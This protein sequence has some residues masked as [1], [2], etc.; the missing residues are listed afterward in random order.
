MLLS[1]RSRKMSK[2]PSVRS[3]PDA[4]RNES[5]S[6]ANGQRENTSSSRL[7]DSTPI[8]DYMEQPTLAFHAPA[9]Y[10]AM[11]PPGSLSPQWFPTF[12]DPPE[13]TPA[14]FVPS[15]LQGH[16]SQH[17]SEVLHQTPRVVPQNRLV[18]PSTSSSSAP[19]ARIDLENLKAFEHKVTTTTDNVYRKIKEGMNELQLL[20]NESNT[21]FGESMILIN[22]CE[23]A[24]KELV[25]ELNRLKWVCFFLRSLN[26]SVFPESS[27]RSNEPHSQVTQIQKKNWLELLKLR[28]VSCTLL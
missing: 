16:Y 22:K 2:R 21:L 4:Q 24:D 18:P 9:M 10:T 8:D 26:V 15:A 25:T 17:P 12:P 5:R 14:I 3:T 19:S 11:L 28:V 6:D 13:G 7:H 20:N 27:W 23:D 1:C